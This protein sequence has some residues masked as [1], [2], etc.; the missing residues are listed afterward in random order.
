[1]LDIF[2]RYVVAWTVQTAA[3]S[4]IA[5]TML[6]EAMGID[7]IPE[8]VHADRGTSMT[9]KAVAQVLLDLG[10]DRSHSRPRVSNDNLAASRR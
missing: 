3:D 4:E 7:G 1:M 9:S 5:K 10:A 6:V 2:S 8:A